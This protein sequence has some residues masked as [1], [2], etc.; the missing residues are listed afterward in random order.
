MMRRGGG[1]RTRFL[2]SFAFRFAFNSSSLRDFSLVAP[3]TVCCPANAVQMRMWVS[4]GKRTFG[5]FSDAVTV[6]VL[7]SFQHLVKIPFVCD[8]LELIKALCDQFFALNLWHF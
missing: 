7:L 6:A 1:A 8:A 3:R 4:V 2:S 5:C